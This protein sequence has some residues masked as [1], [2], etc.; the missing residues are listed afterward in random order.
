M[1]ITPRTAEGSRE[2]LEKANAAKAARQAARRASSLRRNFSDEPWWKKLARARGIRLPGWGEPVR[3]PAMRRW[4]KRLNI[5]VS[6]YLEWQG[7][8]PYDATTGCNRRATVKDFAERNPD[9]SLR[10]WVGLLL[11]SFPAASAVPTAPVLG[12]VMLVRWG[13]MVTRQGYEVPR[14]DRWAMGRIQEVRDTTVTMSV[15]VINEGMLQD[16]VSSGGC[17][18]GCTLDCHDP[19]GLPGGA[20]V[21]I[22][23][24]GL[25][26]SGQ[27]E[28][29]AFRWVVWDDAIAVIQ[30]MPKATSA[31]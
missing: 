21:R 17:V 25:T 16:K 11:E 15:T 27:T 29:D 24:E 26:C 23:R 13:R 4:L 2:L 6:D 5:S 19:D 12:D 30:A 10:A 7:D 9:W 31:A 3:P 22:Q 1:G 28:P 18:R 8:G 20:L 14:C